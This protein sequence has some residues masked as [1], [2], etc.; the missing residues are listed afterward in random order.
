MGVTV[1]R[2]T[3]RAGSTRGCVPLLSYH[4]NHK[5]IKNMG[6]VLTIVRRAAGA[7]VRERRS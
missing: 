6:E 1:D 4:R 7:R 5:I 2:L 3:R